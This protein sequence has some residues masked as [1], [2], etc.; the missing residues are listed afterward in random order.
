M[1]DGRPEQ[2]VERPDA[3]DIKRCC[4]RLYESEIVTRLLGDS[5]HPGGLG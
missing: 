4:A 2:A 3:A 1:N 5:F